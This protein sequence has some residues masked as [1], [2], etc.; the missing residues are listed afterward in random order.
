MPNG[1]L[2][3]INIL[4]SKLTKEQVDEYISTSWLD[5]IVK[6]YKD[7]ECIIKK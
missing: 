4:L 1:N 3:I 5:A 7:R 6:D 2:E